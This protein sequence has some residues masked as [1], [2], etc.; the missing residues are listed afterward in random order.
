M[1]SE[2]RA[3]LIYAGADMLLMPSKSEPCGLSQLIA[4]RYGTL[5]V[6]HAV[7]GLRDTVR[8]YPLDNSNG[9]S[10][11]DYSTDALLGTVDYAVGVYYNK[12][13]WRSLMKR[14][15]TEDLGWSRSAKEYIDVYRKITQ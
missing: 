6:V 10:F 14:A 12:E 13:Q 4:M 1:Y 7:G 9:F 11:G 15:M 3:S 5:P 8:P 2:Q